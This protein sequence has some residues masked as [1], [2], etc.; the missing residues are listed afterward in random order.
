M[1]HAMRRIGLTLLGMGALLVVACSD[2][3]GGDPGPNDPGAQRPP[4]DLTILSLAD[5]APPLYQ[6]SVTFWAVRGQDREGR[7]YFANAEGG[8]GEEYMRLR[9]ESGSLLARPDGTPIAVGDSVQITLTALDPS[10]TLFELA[11]EGLKFNASLPAELKIRY[12]ECG[13][14]LNRDGRVDMNDREIEQEI[15]IWRQATVNDPFV[16]LGT[17]KVEELREVE[18][19]LTS[20]SRY[21]IAY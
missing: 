18:A 19:E 9:V 20:F 13:D 10:R 7:I 15:G 14:D 1:N 11:P 8:P 21:A 12:G 17:A 4:A 6:A 3:N 2:S 5:T 16:R